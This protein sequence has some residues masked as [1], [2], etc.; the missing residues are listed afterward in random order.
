MRTPG[1][2]GQ[3]SVLA[4]VVSTECLVRFLLAL[5]LQDF[6][7]PGPG[8]EDRLAAFGVPLGSPLTAPPGC[9]SALAL[10]TETSIERVGKVG[11]PQIPGGPE[12][13]S[14]AGV[15]QGQA[16]SCSAPYSLQVPGTE[17]GGVERT[18]D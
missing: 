7:L 3:H 10:Q 11:G 1:P 9:F 18:D 6:G 15:L 14:T 13:P 5:S 8:H 17:H 16:E 2:P 4:V 12:N